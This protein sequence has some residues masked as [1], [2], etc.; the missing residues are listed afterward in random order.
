MCIYVHWDWLGHWSIVEGQGER[1]KNGNQKGA[2]DREKQREKK[3]DWVTRIE[4]YSLNCV[5]SLAAKDTVT[6]YHFS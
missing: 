4:G 2:D 3:R 5:A 6:P 1:V